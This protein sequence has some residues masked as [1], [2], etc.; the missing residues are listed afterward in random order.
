MGSNE[1]K[2]TVF[3][4]VHAYLKSYFNQNYSAYRTLYAESRSVGICEI[5]FTVQKL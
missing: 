3:L 5:S 4:T 2:S 1:D